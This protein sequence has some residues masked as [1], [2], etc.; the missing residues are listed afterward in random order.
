MDAPSSS[1][2]CGMFAVLIGL[3]LAVFLGVGA[4]GIS[5]D[6]TPNLDTVE[7][8]TAVDVAVPEGKTVKVTFVGTD[9]EP[10]AGTDI[11]LAYYDE[12]VGMW[13]TLHSATADGA[14]AEFIVPYA[15]DDA[16]AVF[17]VAL[18]EEQV[19]E[20]IEQVDAGSMFAYQLPAGEPL[21][22]MQINEELLVTTLEG[23]MQITIP[24]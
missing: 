8:D 22:A 14:P 9:G 11:W 13:V 1:N 12:P 3:L 15:E 7:P 19:Q 18:S 17:I 16:S 20:F 21:L 5:T 10:V 6:I 2:G 23:T 24:G 4:W